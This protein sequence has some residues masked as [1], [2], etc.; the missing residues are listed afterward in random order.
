MDAD[1]ELFAIF[2]AEVEEQV[3]DLCDH[4]G[5]R[6]DRWRVSRLFQI[7]HN[8][9]GAARLVGVESIRDAAHALED[10]FSG[11]RDGDI[12]LSEEVVS[13]AR[14]G[15][16]LVSAAFEAIDTKSATPNLADYRQAVNL[17]LADSQNTGAQ[18]DDGP[19]EHAPQHEP[20]RASDEKPD[21]ETEAESVRESRAQKAST[22]RVG[23]EKVDTLLGLASE[24]VSLVFQAEGQ[25]SYAREVT[26]HI[27]LLMKSHPELAS[28]PEALSLARMSREMV[29]SLVD[30]ASSALRVSDELQASVRGLRMVRFEGLR[31]L[32]SRSV[33]SACGESGRNAT[34]SITGGATEV[35]RVVLDQLRDPLVHLLRNAVAH[36]IESPS[37]RKKAGK[38][39]KGDIELRARSHGPWVEIAVRDDGRGIDVNV[40]RK[41]ALETGLITPKELE[42]IDDRGAL[43]LLFL[44][45]F[46]TVDEV[47]ELSGRGV[48]L[49]V[50]KSQLLR[51]GGEATIS[52]HVGE[53]TEVLLRVPLTRLT[54]SGIVV[55]VNDQLFSFPTSEVERTVAVRKDDVTIADGTE[56]IHIDGSLVRIVHLASILGA[57]PSEHDETPAVVIGDGVRRRALIVDEVVGQRDYILQQ[58][59]WNLEGAPAIAGTSVLDGSTVVLVLDNHALLGY[60]NDRGSAFA[61]SSDERQIRV[62]VVDDSATSRTLERNILRSAGYD[63]TTAVDG[64]EAL[65]LLHRESFDLV[66]SDVEMPVVGGIEL[67]QR[68]RE[69]AKLEHLPVV[70]VTSLGS[71]ED[72]RLGAEVGAD[73]YIVK[74]AFDQDELLR[75]IGRL[76]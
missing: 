14:R 68:I 50:V 7:S 70:L 44:G 52:S 74:G 32:L 23:T 39:E 72:K 69:E 27:D 65:V 10:L 75:T 22:L 5:R 26:K 20:D 37:D 11:I 42:A 12:G 18:P 62:L 40:V 66:V 17:Q 49:D 73:A 33:R 55:E 59:C 51:L 24:F 56:V 71:D 60:R 57:E 61:E 21:K 34:L 41:R 2:R 16:D 13:L 43:D 64:R 67:T 1:Q 54:T 63:V 35:D 29:R 36:G 28:L 31:T 48:G 3:E 25:A 9:K 15:A 38:N 6:P 4:L 47:S 30:H 76:L 53:G 8:V 45:G 19:S 58:L 46:S